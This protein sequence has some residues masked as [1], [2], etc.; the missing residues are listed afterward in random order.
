LLDRPLIFD[1]A[2]LDDVVTG[3]S[4]L[5]Y[6][7]GRGAAAYFGVSCSANVRASS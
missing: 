4:A 7:L 2:E 5:T 3:G 1:K 6:G